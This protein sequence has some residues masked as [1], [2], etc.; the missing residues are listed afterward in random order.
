M[1]FNQSL[2]KTVNNVNPNAAA[3][4]EL[5]KRALSGLANPHRDSDA[6]QPH[7]GR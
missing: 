4:R 6:V 1:V 7:V 2:G 5:P 3:H